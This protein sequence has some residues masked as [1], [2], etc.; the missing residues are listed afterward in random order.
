[1]PGRRASSSTGPPSAG[2]WCRGEAHGRRAL[3]LL[4]AVAT[5]RLLLSLFPSASRRPHRDAAAQPSPHIP[6]N[7]QGRLGGAPPRAARPQH[8]NSLRRAPCCAAAPRQTKAP[9][10]GMAAEAA[11]PARADVIDEVFRSAGSLS[12]RPR[13]AAPAD[14]SRR[15]RRSPTRAGEEQFFD[16]IAGSTAHDAAQVLRCSLNYPHHQVCAEGH[17]V[18]DAGGPVAS[19]Q[20]IR[21]EP[22]GDAEGAKRALDAESKLWGSAKEQSWRSRPR[23][24]GKALR[25]AQGRHRRGRSL[26]QGRDH[27]HA[28][29]GT[30]LRRLDG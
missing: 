17:H 22:R 23:R 21:G 20:S 9:Q 3:A 4:S 7:S 14:Q 26:Q 19:R 12:P 2:E 8:L 16:M 5:T 30:T 13:P 25:K 28:T 29:R 18:A 27:R 24:N 11:T 1:M 6:S 10:Q 15:S